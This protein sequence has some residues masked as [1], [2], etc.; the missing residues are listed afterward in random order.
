MDHG[1]RKFC[2]KVAE[3]VGFE[4]TVPT[5]GTT[6]FE[7]APFDH[8]GTS[9]HILVPRETTRPGDRA[10]PDRTVYSK[11]HVQQNQDRH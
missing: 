4:P 11:Q 6:D 8:S 7:S 2:R 3:R 5:R 10:R 1:G 9:P